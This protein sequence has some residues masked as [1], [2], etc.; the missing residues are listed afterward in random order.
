MYGAETF[1]TTTGTQKLL[2]VRRL[3]ARLVFQ[4]DKVDFR[5][6]AANCVHLS[7]L[8]YVCQT[9]TLKTGN[10]AVPAVEVLNVTTFKLQQNETDLAN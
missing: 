1:I 2:V 5:K 4:T 6:G 10:R 8:R 3:L 7:S 9:S